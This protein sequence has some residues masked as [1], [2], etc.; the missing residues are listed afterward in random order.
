MCSCR[1]FQTYGLPCGHAIAAIN[2][3]EFDPYD[4]CNECFDSERYQDTYAEVVH[5]TLDRTQ[6]HESLE[7]LVTILPPLTKR[8]PERPRTRRTDR[9][10]KSG[11]RYKCTRCR[12]LGHNR[13]SCKEPPVVRPN[14]DESAI[15]PSALTLRR[16]GVPCQAPF[17]A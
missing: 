13:R 15:G 5:T 6:W 12:Q 8:P 17:F 11:L 7:P 14:L 4:Y 3:T 1:A 9:E 2:I 10:L 16:S